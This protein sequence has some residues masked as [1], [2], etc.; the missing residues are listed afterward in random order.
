MK[1]HPLKLAWHLLKRAC[2]PAAPGGQSLP[3]RRQCFSFK[4]LNGLKRPYPADKIRAHALFFGIN[5]AALPEDS[6]LPS[7]RQLSVFR[8]REKEESFFTVSSQ[9]YEEEK[10]A[11]SRTS[12]F[13]AGYNSALNLAQIDRSLSL[14]N[15]TPGLEV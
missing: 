6:L 13:P 2:R 14:L 11:F 3:P 5:P 4:V 12:A 9:Q 10:S 1:I 7:R 8:Y 15:P